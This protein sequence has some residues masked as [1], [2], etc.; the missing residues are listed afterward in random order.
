MLKYGVGPGDYDLPQLLG[1]SKTVMKRAS[2][3]FTISP[4]KHKEL[5][6][7]FQQNKYDTVSSLDLKELVGNILR[8]REFIREAPLFDG[9]LKTP[10]M[11]RSV[12]HQFSLLPRFSPPPGHKQYQLNL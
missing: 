3:A 9:T 4:N 6:V 5:Q 1:Q 8:G 12:N 2:P 7:P 10:V 11:K